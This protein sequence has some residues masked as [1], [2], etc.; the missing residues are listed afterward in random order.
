MY[1]KIWLIL[2]SLKQI[3]NNAYI[4]NVI[5]PV[6]S[7]DKN[8]ITYKEPCLTALF[9]V[10]II[11][12]FSAFINVSST[13]RQAFLRD[14]CILKVYS[15]CPLYCRVSC[16]LWK[17]ASAKQF[18]GRL[19]LIQFAAR[20]QQRYSAFLSFWTFIISAG[21][22]NQGITRENDCL[23]DLEPEISQIKAAMAKA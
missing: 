3:R 13:D 12:S 16:Y 10:T 5:R 21:C 7:G 15:S 9:Y 18:S 6:Q 17:S 20:D 2:Q 4:R 8:K 23:P 11:Q 1:L 19:L 22:W 14:L